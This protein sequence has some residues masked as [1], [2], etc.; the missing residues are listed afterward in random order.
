MS[1]GIATW[2]VQ[3]RANRRARRLPPASV[4]AAAIFLAIVIVCASVGSLLAPFSASEEHL[5]LGMTSPSSTHLLG[6]DTL[7]RDVLSRLIVAARPSVVGPVCVAAGTLVF[8]SGLGLFAGFTGGLPDGLLS[9]FAELVY[10]MPAILVAVVVV[11]VTGGGYWLTVALLVFLS[12]PSDFRIARSATMTQVRLP[13]VDAARVL[14]LSRRRI[15]LAHVLPNILPTVVA[16]LSLDFVGAL[17]GFSSLAFLGI[18]VPPGSAEWG[19][20]LSDGQS[21]IL[22]N[23]WLSVAPAVVLIATAAS[24]TLVGDWSYDRVVARRSAP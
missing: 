11:G 18:G 14:G 16:N 19:S 5:F 1:S 23:P 20:M 17:I 13:Y 22:T 21:V 3:L 15:M 10:S 9:R 12:I 2:G 24:A 8:G 6:T 7:G 4:V